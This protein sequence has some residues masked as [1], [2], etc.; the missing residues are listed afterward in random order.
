MRLTRYGEGGGW[1]RKVQGYTLQSYRGVKGEKR[2]SE[3]KGIAPLTGEDE[4][5]SRRSRR[6]G[7]AGSKRPARL[8]F[9]Y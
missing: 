4:G 9:S 6:K 2:E 1:G 7:G 3:E 5:I 8:Y